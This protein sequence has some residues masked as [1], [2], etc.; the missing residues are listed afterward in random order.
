MAPAAP[1]RALTGLLVLAALLASETETSTPRRAP[2]K[3]EKTE[4]A[5]AKVEVRRKDKALRRKES[6]KRR[7]K[8]HR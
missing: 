1:P 7:K 4:E 5:Q 3:P 6:A 8:G 2:N